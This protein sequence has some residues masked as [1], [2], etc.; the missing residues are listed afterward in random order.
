MDKTLSHAPLN[1][2]LQSRLTSLY[3]IPQW[4]WEAQAKDKD[5]NG[6][7][8]G[9]HTGHESHTSIFRFMI[10]YVTGETRTAESVLPEIRYRWHILTFVSYW[11][12]EG[13][14]RLLCLFPKE[15]F[16][17]YASL[18]GD[19]KQAFEETSTDTL[20]SHPF[21]AH[22]L[23][24]KQVTRLYDQAI[25]QFRGYVR[26]TEEH[27]P[28]IE[29]P[30]TNYVAMHE[31]ARHTMHCSEVLATALNV[32]KNMLEEFDRVTSTCK[33]ELKPTSYDPGPEIR[34][35]N[36]VLQFMHNRSLAIED[37]LRNEINLALHITS[38][39]ANKLS[40]EIAEAARVDSRTQKTISVLG[41]LFLPGTFISALFSMSF[42]NFTQATSTSPASWSMSPKFWIY[43]VVAIPITALTVATW[44]IWQK[45]LLTPNSNL[46]T[47]KTVRR[48]PT[49][50]HAYNTSKV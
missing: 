19:M 13:T 2:E 12:T 39:H 1:N 21:A 7:F 34:H 28:S 10:K 47:G 43:W 15:D 45:S 11:K 42:F 17:G 32:M 38:Q 27:R 31:L 25:R 48:C 26:E 41:L 33:L 40:A 22:P 5:Y 36:S 18:R 14:V 49:P 24:L 23:V 46:S 20:S 30:H 9:A 35:R 8:Y 6:F 44:W 29:K 4:L 3:N 37:R 16:S 50:S